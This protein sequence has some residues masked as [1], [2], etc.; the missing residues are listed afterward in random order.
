MTIMAT[1]TMSTVST[2]ISTT[3]LVDDDQHHNGSDHVHQVNASSEVV[4]IAFEA[5]RYSETNPGVVIAVYLGTHPNTPSRARIREVLTQDFR[6]AGLQDPITFFFAQNDV[7]GSAATI[8]YG[9]DVDGPHALSA[10]RERAAAVTKSY[11]FRK[12]RGLHE[13]QN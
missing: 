9:G 11:N 4:D 3:S 12:E 8:H 13:F 1:M 2:S 10:T 5:Q 6:E 7:E